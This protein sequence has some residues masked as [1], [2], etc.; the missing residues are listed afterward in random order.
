MTGLFTN[1]RNKLLSH[2]TSSQKNSLASN[3][4][5]QLSS[6]HHTTH[7]IARDGQIKVRVAPPLV[8]STKNW[9]VPD[10]QNTIT[11]LFPKTLG[12]WPP[13]H[14]EMCQKTLRPRP[15]KHNKSTQ[16]MYHC[17]PRPQTHGKV[18]TKSTSSQLGEQLSYNLSLMHQPAH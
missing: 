2:V 10:Q 13:K 17:G 7:S 9:P 3:L 4:P 5:L 18:C 1:C 16:N 14:N 15:T 8:P 6:V 11:I 12:P